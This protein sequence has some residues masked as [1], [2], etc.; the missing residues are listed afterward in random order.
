MERVDF[1]REFPRSGTLPRLIASRRYHR[2]ASSQVQRSPA[3]LRW[4]DLT[5]VL[6]P[7]GEQRQR[8]ARRRYTPEGE[9]G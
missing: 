4:T 2:A 8:W 6:P 9:T 1:P 5:A 7:C 3:A